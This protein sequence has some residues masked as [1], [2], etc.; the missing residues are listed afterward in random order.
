MILTTCAACEQKVMLGGKI[1]RVRYRSTYGT[2][3]GYG[4]LVIQLTYGTYL[5]YGTVGTY[6]TM[7]PPNTGSHGQWTI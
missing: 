1:K 3:S 4:S 6:G 7:V 2:Y 5:R